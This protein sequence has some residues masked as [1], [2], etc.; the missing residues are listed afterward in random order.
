MK[1]DMDLIRGIL[2]YVEEHDGMSTVT[3][4][5]HFEPFTEREL[6]EAVH[7]L[8]GHGLVEANIQRS[9]TTPGGIYAAVVNRL[10]WEGHDFLEAARNETIWERT[11]AQIAE[12]GGGASFEV[13]KALLTA[14]AKD[15]FGV[16][17]GG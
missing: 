17:T 1:R 6:H 14:A 16:G 15:Y 2:L 8:E 12:K 7:L 3:D 9:G 13:I 5:E 4:R 10:T 11:K